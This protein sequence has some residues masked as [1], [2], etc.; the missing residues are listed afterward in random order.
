MELPMNEVR[1]VG[2]AQDVRGTGRRLFVV[3][4]ENLGDLPEGLPVGVRA[5]VLFTAVDGTAASEQ[6]LK[7]FARRWLEL[8]CVW[9]CSWG[10]DAGRMELAFDLVEVDAELA[11]ERLRFDCVTTSHETESLDDALWFAVHAA[12]LECDAMVAVAEGNWAEQIEV[13][14]SDGKTWSHKLLAAE[15]EENE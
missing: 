2:Q 10:P 6:Q 5:F 12:E 14:L 15:E 9:A 13:R 7:D 4:I 8:G 1:L 11:G 3:R